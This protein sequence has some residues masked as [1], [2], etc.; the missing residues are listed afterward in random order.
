[1]KRH[2]FWAGPLLAAALMVGCATNPVTERP[3]FTIVNEQMEIEMGREAHGEV[4]KEFGAY[5]ASALESYVADVGGKVASVSHRKELPYQFTVLDSPIINAFA[6]P[7]GFVYVTRGLLANL[8]SEAEL[9]A[10]LGHEVGHVTARH[11]AQAVTRVTTYQVLTGLITALD[12]RLASLR[13]LSDTSANLIFL[14]YGRDAEYQADELGAQYSFN[15]GYDPRWLGVFLRSL[16]AQEQGQERPPEFLST[17]PSTPARV[18]RADTLANDLIA[19]GADGLKVD[20]K[21]YRSHL[22]GLLFGPGPLGWIWQGGRLA[23]KAHKIALAPPEDWNLQTKRLVFEIRH[24]RVQG[25]M[26]EWRIHEK[27]TTVSVDLFAKRIEEQIKLESPIRS[28]FDLGPLDG[29]KVVYSGRSEGT[30]A[31]LIIYYAQDGQTGYT[32]SAITPVDF[33][34]RLEPV[35]DELARSLVKLN[36]SEADAIVIQKIHLEEARSGEKLADLVRRVYG[37]TDHLKAIALLN[38]LPTDATLSGGALTKVILPTPTVK[39]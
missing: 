7:G 19:Q 18:E 30:D 17:H 16:A 1:M 31:V 12:E 27:L 23:N 33:R 20:S 32:L 4:V 15:S 38:S 9:A 26:A 34:D 14:K 5:G 2:I 37:N 13:T 8:G 24:F 22:E 11:G 10:V 35:Y 3:E 39:R 21:D 25:A 28:S 29:L 36:A 6:L